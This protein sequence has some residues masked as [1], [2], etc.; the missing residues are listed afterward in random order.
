MAYLPV[1]YASRRT[2]ESVTLVEAASRAK[3]ASWLHATP[4][5][6]L[7]QNRYSTSVS[8]HCGDGGKHCKSTK[9]EDDDEE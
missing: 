8:V 7:V 9:E 2:A 1:Q 4:A 5:A 6:D 3:K